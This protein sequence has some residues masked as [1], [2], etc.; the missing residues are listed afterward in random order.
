MMAITVMSRQLSGEVVLV[1]AVEWGSRYP[2][3][4]RL[5]LF[6]C[7]LNHKGGGGWVSKLFGYRDSSVCMRITDKNGGL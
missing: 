2:K 7:V 1:S 5:S 3:W 6:K 4:F